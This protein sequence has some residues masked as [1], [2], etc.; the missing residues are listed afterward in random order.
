[1]DKLTKLV[2]EK[3]IEQK[4]AYIS[5]EFVE[6]LHIKVRGKYVRFHKILWDYLPESSTKVLTETAKAVSKLAIS[7]NAEIILGI[8]ASGIAVASVASVIS[9]RK[10]GFIRKK[11]KTYGLQRIIEGEFSENKRAII[12]DN[13]YFSGGTLKSAINKA[14]AVGL[15]VILAVC[16]DGFTELANPRM[17]NGVPVKILINNKEKVKYLLKKKYFPKNLT[18]YIADY[19][20]NPLLYIE[21]SETYI[22]FT[23]EIKKHKNNQVVIETKNR[24]HLNNFYK[25]ILKFLN[26]LKIPI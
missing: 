24:S 14:R 25:K 22:N 20:E 6:D 19:I 8:E 13:F 9:G 16:V 1:M 11:S 15:K 4:C 7:S 2:A 23:N 3:T 10:F 5:A 17:I 21:N 18:P 26:A 12:V